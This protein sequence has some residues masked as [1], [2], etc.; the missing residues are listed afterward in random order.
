MGDGP[1][2]HPVAPPAEGL[3]LGPPD[4]LRGGPQLIPRPPDWRPGAAP[5]WERLPHSLRVPTVAQVRVAFDG[6][7]GPRAVPKVE[8]AD[9]EPERSS[10][11]LAPL[12]DDGG[13]AHIL[14]TRRSWNLRAHRGEISFPGGRAEPTDPDLVATALR[15]T[16]EEVG[17]EPGQIEVIG[18]L[19]PLM[20]VSSRSFIAP[21]VGLLRGRPEVVPDPREV[22]EVRHVALA[23][24]LSDGVYHQEIWRRDGREMPLH[25]FELHG[26][27]VWGATA[28]ML[29]QL[30]ILI[31]GTGARA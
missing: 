25:F 4:L 1:Y 22:E 30:L 24:L 23:E 3:P 31:T 10:A 19:D 5:P 9:G 8:S 26:D 14:L 13:V 7:R 11:V 17:I 27:T 15:E 12:Y 6:W 16:N 20:T 21:F 18:Q 28:S 2:D 29:H